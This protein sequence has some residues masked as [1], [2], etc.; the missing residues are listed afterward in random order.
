MS[1]CAKKLMRVF[2]RGGFTVEEAKKVDKDRW[3]GFECGYGEC[4]KVERGLL[5][6]RVASSMATLEERDRV[7]EGGG[8]DVGANILC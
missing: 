5:G 2:L 1:R 7:A 3:D 4:V 6:E 8:A